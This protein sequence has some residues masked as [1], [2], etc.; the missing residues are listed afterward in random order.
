M[1]LNELQNCRFYRKLTANED[2]HTMLKVEKLT[3]KYAENL[4]ENEIDFL[5]NFE[6]KSSNFYGLPKVHKSKEIQEAVKNCDDAYIK[7][8]QPAD[9]KIRPIIAGP[10]SSTQRLSNLLDILLKPLCKLLPSFVRD[11][12]DFLNYIPQNV[13]PNTILVSFD[14]TSLYTNIPHTLGL[15][16][17]SYWI[18]KHPDIINERFPKEFI[19]EGL[20]IVLENNHFHFNNEFYI[21][22]KGTA[23]GTKVA[24][25][26]ATL[27]MGYLEDQLYGKIPE[28][29]DV[30]FANYIKNNWKRYLDDCFIFWTRS[31]EDLTQFH[32]LL[33]NLHDS[34]Q[35]TIEKSRKELPF[36]DLLIIKNGS[37]I[38]TDLY[39]KPTDTH[40]YLDFRSCHPSHTKRNIPFNL[41]RRICTIITDETLRCRRLEELKIYLRRQ[42][43]PL[44]LINI[45]I[46]KASEIPIEDLRNPRR[47]DDTDDDGKIAFVVTHNPRNRNILMDAKRFYPI[48]EQSEN[49]KSLVQPNDI[50]NSRRQA[51]NLKKLLTKAR[52]TT[53][54]EIPTIKKCGDP[55]CGTCSYLEEGNKIQLKSGME[56]RTNS[57]MNC[58]SENV[59]Y[60]AICPTCKEYYIGQTGKL[61]ARVRV[62]KQQIKDPS[63]RN[64][65]CCEHFAKCGKGIFKIF[66]FYK[67]PNENE[68]LRLAKEDY[69]INLF[70]PKLNRK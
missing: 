12:M 36:L 17:V 66:P 38:T 29:F 4:T 39:C 10:A 15:E 70:K 64:T 26:Y 43:Y 42:N 23:M 40:Q 47:I 2:R 63:V 56:I 52:F 61:N 14:V 58:K 18:D 53:Q 35:F 48:L 7:I 51:P 62:H 1:V 67:L 69:F 32:S 34:I 59:I 11:D 33:N 68:N 37:C 19:L 6:L 55:R 20:K 60:C 13:D 24:P 49:M 65:P 9:L 57:S 5:T 22:I 3:K 45:G 30:D 31:E 54:E 41:A 44:D 25:S 16:A 28:L 50:I 46:E 27:V 8:S 21:Q